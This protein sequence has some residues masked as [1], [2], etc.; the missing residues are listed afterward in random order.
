MHLYT[1]LRTPQVLADLSLNDEQMRELLHH[2][3]YA[4]PQTSLRFHNP[5]GPC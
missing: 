4:N 3:M 5:P 1:P 2:R